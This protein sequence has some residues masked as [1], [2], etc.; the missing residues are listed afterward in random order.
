MREPAIRTKKKRGQGTEKAVASTMYGCLRRSIHSKPSA[1]T[2]VVPWMR[3]Q[4]T[5]QLQK[6]RRSLGVTTVDHAALFVLR[7]RLLVVKEVLV[8]TLYNSIS[9]LSTA[10]DEA[11][12]HPTAC[13]CL[14]LL[15]LVSRP[16]RNGD[17]SILLKDLGSK[18]TFVP[19][20]LHFLW[21]FCLDGELQSLP[22]PDEWSCSLR[23]SWAFS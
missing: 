8:Q 13:W 12:L 7:R 18:A 15:L 1:S 14:L 17:C 5:P 16:L 21:F 19:L 10:V 20:A 6:Q 23:L 3:F 22:A 11:S 4:Y 9:S 2:S